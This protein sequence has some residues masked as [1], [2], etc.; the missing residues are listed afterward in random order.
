MGQDTHRE[1]FDLVPNLPCPQTIHRAYPSS[2]YVPGKHTP[3]HCD[4]VAPE[5]LLYVPPL[6]T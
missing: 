3:E 2:L 4:V 1:L 5:V 6:H